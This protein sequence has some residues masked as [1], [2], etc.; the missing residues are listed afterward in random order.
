MENN[1]VDK[2]IF[3]HTY[4]K[5]VVLDKNSLHVFKISINT[6][7][8]IENQ[9]YEIFNEEEIDIA[10]RYTRDEDKKRYILG[11]FFLRMIL[12]KMLSITPSAIQF[13]RNENNR[14]YCIEG[15]EFNISHSGNFI[16]IAISPQLVGIDIEL[17]NNDFEYE[18]ILIDC[19]TFL[20][21][22]QVDNANDFYKFW[23]RKESILKATG[24][25]MIGN[26][27]TIDCSKSTVFRDNLNFKLTSHYIDNS[28]MMSFATIEN[29]SLGHNY[30][31][32]QV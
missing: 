10:S 26:L 14:P 23:T 7:N 18:S 17:I 2:E 5:N 29:P 31:S 25:G 4:D 11:K 20:E 3:W 22:S 13:F 12:S 15:L 19:F 28:Y 24:E 6:Y 21:L 30:W 27:H 8:D 1:L 16:V 9:Y 32:I